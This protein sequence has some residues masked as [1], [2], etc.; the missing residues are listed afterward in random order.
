MD[1]ITEEWRDIL[2]FS[3]AYQV[4]S[5]GRIRSLPRKVDAINRWGNP[6]KLNRVGGL[7]KL[8]S[9]PNGYQVVGLSKDGKIT[10]YSVHRLVAQAFI[11]N[12]AA[13]PITNHKN[14]NKKDNRVD[15]LE[16]CSQ[17]YNT[18]H[19]YTT[20]RIKAIGSRVN[21]SKL[22]DYQVRVI[23]ELKGVLS[24]TVLGGYFKVSQSAIYSIYSGKTWGHVK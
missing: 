1:D 14:R 23:R 10:H 21:G 4:S 15:N 3:G 9:T 17:S 2:E 7:R 18:K 20:G 16:W 5:L 22:D 24:Q 13:F 8:G 12:P 6:V 19:C 11:S